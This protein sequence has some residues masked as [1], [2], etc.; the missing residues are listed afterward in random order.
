MRRMHKRI[1]VQSWVAVSLLG[2]FSLILMDAGCGPSPSKV[3]GL[4]P[5]FRSDDWDVHFETGIAGQSMDFSPDGKLLAFATADNAVVL[6]NVADLT[7]TKKWPTGQ[8]SSLAFPLRVQFSPDGTS[9]VTGGEAPV[10]I[11]W[12]LKTFEK[13]ASANIQT[14][15]EFRGSGGVVNHACRTIDWSPRGD[16]ILTTAG[17]KD[18]QIWSAIDGSR[19]GTC[20]GHTDFVEAAFYVAGGEMIATCSYDATVRLWDA[21]TFETLGE[22]EGHPDRIRVLAVGE[23]GANVATGGITTASR[24]DSVFLWDVKSQM[25]LKRFKH[26]YNVEIIQFSPD[27][28]HLLYADRYE[29]HV[30]ALPSGKE[31]LFAEL[32]NFAYLPEFVASGD[33]VAVR[34]HQKNV[35]LLKKRSTAPAAK[36]AF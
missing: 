8:K 10:F 16:A 28:K 26:N 17:G 34:D 27:G 2:L 6:L 15:A 4:H 19:I 23:G 13:A 1:Q 29:V 25:V 12:D 5:L 32:K 14:P 11:V 18:A 22:L 31:E 36:K 30:H 21:T 35:T 3:T 33:F 20:I 7:V 9:L 24:R